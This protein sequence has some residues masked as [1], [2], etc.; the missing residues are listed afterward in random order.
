[1]RC[2]LDEWF[3]I[4]S[5][6]SLPKGNLSGWKYHWWDMY[7]SVMGHLC[8]L[9]WLK[10]H[11]RWSLERCFFWA[12][13]WFI[14]RNIPDSWA[15]FIDLGLPWIYME[16]GDILELNTPQTPWGKTTNLEWTLVSPQSLSGNGKSQKH[17][18]L[19]T[20]SFICLAHFHNH[21]RFPHRSLHHCTIPSKFHS[22]YRDF[23]WSRSISR[24]YPASFQIA[25][26]CPWQVGWYT[27]AW[28]SFGCLVLSHGKRKAEKSA[29]LVVGWSRGNFTELSKLPK[30]GVS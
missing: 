22:I 15:K 9:D 11:Y 20:I 18:L 17:R 3:S 4:V 7:I 19:I 12:L 1:M 28:T 2:L 24:G 10:Y 13:C 5:Y 25:R 21:P 6:V 16:A 26:A 8:F 29:E 30:I 23:S 14:L 27:V